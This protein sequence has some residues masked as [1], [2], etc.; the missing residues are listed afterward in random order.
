MKGFF[1]I[2]RLVAV[3]AGMLILLE[4]NNAEIAKLDNH[5]GYVVDI[6]NSNKVIIVLD[7]NQHLT[8]PFKKLAYGYQPRLGDCVKRTWYRVG[9]KSLPKLGK[10]Y[11]SLE[12]YDS[13]SQRI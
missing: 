7:A 10:A 8:I 3:F 13:P 12:N 1:S 2:L 11:C 6:D 4:W 5:V 9:W